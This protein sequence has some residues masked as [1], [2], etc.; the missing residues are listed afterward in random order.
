MYKC[1]SWSSKSVDFHLETQ[2]LG[3]RLGLENQ[4]LLTTLN[5]DETKISTALWV[6]RLT[7]DFATVFFFVLVCQ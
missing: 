6:L 3:L 4:I 7:K 5:A 1:W 2:S